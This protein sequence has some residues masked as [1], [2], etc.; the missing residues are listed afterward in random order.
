[1]LARLRKLAALVFYLRKQARI[2]YRQHRLHSK[3]LKQVDGTQMKFTRRPAT[4][5]KCA[6]D[7]ARSQERREAL[8]V[9][10][11]YRGDAPSDCAIVGPGTSGWRDQ[12]TVLIGRR[13]F[14]TLLG[15]AAAAWPLPALGAAAGDAGD[16]ISQRWVAQTVR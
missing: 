6:D 8:A 12:V 4:D 7:R 3:A 10:F 16:R 1:V 11:S 5:N 9:V 2:L 15:S 14:V 13:G